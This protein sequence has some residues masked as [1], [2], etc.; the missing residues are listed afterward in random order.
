MYIKRI[1]TYQKLV[2]GKSRFER[3]KYYFCLKACMVWIIQCSLFIRFM[4]FCNS[5]RSAISYWRLLSYIK[6]DFALTYGHLKVQKIFKCISQIKLR[7][8]IGSKLFLTG[9]PKNLKICT[10]CWWKWFRGWSTSA[11][12]LFYNITNPLVSSYLRRI[13][14]YF[15]MLT[16]YQW[17]KVTTV[18][19]F[20]SHHL[21]S[22]KEG[23]IYSQTLR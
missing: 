4:C 19:H 7:K 21:L 22:F 1:L 3:S 6:R 12:T 9:R 2:S 16:P 18:L 15:G 20:H 5:K 14:K 17:G 23:I 11:N 8:E 13:A 10:A